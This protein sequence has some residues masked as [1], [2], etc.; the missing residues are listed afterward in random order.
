MDLYD[1]LDSGP[2]TAQGD[3]IETVDFINHK[4]LR[5]RGGGSH[6]RT[7]KQRARKA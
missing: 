5:N 2:Q 4:V 7:S 1:T 3:L 6:S